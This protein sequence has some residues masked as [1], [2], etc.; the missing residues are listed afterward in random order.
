[1]KYY[2]ILI[3][4]VCSICYG[5]SLPTETLPKRQ[6]VF[7]SVEDAENKKLFLAALQIYGAYLATFAQKAE[8]CSM[9]GNPIQNYVDAYKKDN[10]Q[11]IEIMLKILSKY[12]NPENGNFSEE[13]IFQKI[14]SITMP[15]R[16]KEMKDLAI[17]SNLSE[18]QL[19]DWFNTNLADTVGKRNLQT[20]SPEVSKLLIHSQYA[21]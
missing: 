4:F 18:K 20:I 5:Q 7:I 14:G 10:K 19:C 15:L 6:P 12:W 16:E 13:K 9:I 8:Y 2:L 1:M 21:K 11:L 3:S 17:K